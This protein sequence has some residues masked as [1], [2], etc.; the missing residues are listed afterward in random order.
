[1]KERL[2]AAIQADPGMISLPENCDQHEGRPEAYL[3][4]VL[5][6]TKG[7]LQRLSRGGMAIK[8]YTKNRWNPGDKLPNGQ[9]VKPGVS[10]NGAGHR[11]HWII[12]LRGP[13]G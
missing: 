4:D 13:N 5:G 2:E 1:M 6:L 7:D 11:K 9:E 12:V 8:A 3:I 10:Y